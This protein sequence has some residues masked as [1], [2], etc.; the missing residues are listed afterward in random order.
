MNA[1]GVLNTCTVF[2]QE[3][4]LRP[5][6]RRR[7]IFRRKPGIYR[8]KRGSLEKY[9]KFWKNLLTKGKWSDIMSKLSARA[10]RPKRVSQAGS[11][12]TLKK[13]EKSSWQRLT[14]V[15]RCETVAT[16]TAALRAANE[17]TKKFKKLEKSSWQKLESVVRSKPAAAER[18]APCK[19]NNVTNTKHQ[20]DWLFQRALKEACW[21]TSII[22][23]KLRF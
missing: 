2:L 8:Q 12:K 11:E 15:V 4:I 20:K 21:T 1:G 16:A 14:D 7:W 13:V 23:L 10:G 19:L 5:C 6:V 18:C 3:E 22:S 9:K 17:R